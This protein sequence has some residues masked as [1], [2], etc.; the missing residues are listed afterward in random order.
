[1]F[2]GGD[3]AYVAGDSGGG[4]REDTVAPPFPPDVVE[5]GG[6]AGMRPPLAIVVDVALGGLDAMPEIRELNSASSAAVV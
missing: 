3:G 5:Y 4:V 6:G 2:A 1:L